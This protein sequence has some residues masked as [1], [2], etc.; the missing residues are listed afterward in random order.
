M[1]I[2]ERFLTLS[3]S[4]IAS[5]SSGQ[6]FSIDWFSVDAIGGTSTG[7]VYS[8][9]G[10]INQIGAG[11]VAGGEYS[12]AG[13]FWQILSAIPVSGAPPLTIQLTLT[14]SVLISWPASSTGFQLQENA[15]LN[16]LTWTKVIVTPLL[17][18]QE[19]QVVVSNSIG[20]RFYR[21]QKP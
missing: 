4:I 14:N 10:T 3:F 21:L 19:M 16:P 9:S 6:S 8:V 20:S 2:R 5:V 11:T 1:N 15:Q 12:L 18:S 17:I 13:G 7:E